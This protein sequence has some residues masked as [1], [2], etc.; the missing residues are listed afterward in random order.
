MAWSPVFI[1]NLSRSARVTFEA[2]KVPTF[3][4][5][6][7]AAGLSV[8]SDQISAGDAAISPGAA[9]ALSA[10]SVAIPSFAVSSAQ[11]RFA[12]CGI[13]SGRDI[14]TALPRGSACEILARQHVGAGIIAPERIILG[15][16]RDVSGIGPQSIVS[17][18]GA[19]SLVISRPLART[20]P[21][22]NDAALF[23]NCQDTGHSLALSSAFNSGATSLQFASAPPMQRETGAPGAVLVT[24]ASGADPYIVTYTG[25]SGNNLTGVSASAI[26]GTTRTNAGAGSVVQEVCLINKH[27]VSMAL[28]VLTSTGT[29]ANGSAD[30]L[31]ESWGL[32]VPESLIDVQGFTDA[33]TALNASLPSGSFLV[34]TVETTPQGPPL[35]WLQGELARY[36]LWL[37]TR[38]GQI[39]IR[40]ALDYYRHRP[41]TVMQLDS[42]NLIAA[43]P[44]RSNFDA[45]LQAEA[46]FFTA[47]ADPLIVADAFL[48]VETPQTRPLISTIADGPKITTS[49][50]VYQNALSIN[51]SIA[52]RVG[53]WHTRVCTV[54]NAQATLEAAQLCVGDWVSIKHLGLWDHTLSPAVTSPLHRAMVTSISC[55]WSAGVVSLRLH[56]QHTATEA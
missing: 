34:H 12:V 30:T 22:T 5:V 7:G 40:A 31:P 39:T 26:F 23:A 20:S 37:C 46:V 54:I 11:W 21:S 47:G 4:I 44:E 14:A 28:A 1:A 33:A 42:D 49:P 35:T 19:L 29:G 45:S 16:S 53:P 25:V 27:P 8:R 6:P 2:Q 24:P 52:Q 50:Y 36:G 17:G 32:A 48:L 41:A 55:D 10:Q 18:W 15:Q 51:T 13:E 38:Q 43:L 56:V 9:L 3:T